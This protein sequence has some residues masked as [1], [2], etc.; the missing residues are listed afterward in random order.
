MKKGTAE[1]KQSH[2]NLH[3]YTPFKTKVRRACFLALLSFRIREKGVFSSVDMTTAAK[4]STHVPSTRALFYALDQK[5][6]S[7]E[8]VLEK[9]DAATPFL[10]QGLKAYGPNNATSR[11]EIESGSI[12]LAG[13][14]IAVGADMQKCTVT[15]AQ[16]LKLDEI[17]TYVMLRRALE[18]KG[19]TARPKELTG[20]LIELVCTFY[21]RERLALL[22]CIAV[23]GTQKAYVFNGESEDGF[24]LE[25]EKE[26]A[27]NEFALRL[28]EK[29][30]E[31]I[32]NGL[33]DNIVNYLC[34]SL[35]ANGEGLGSLASGIGREERS[36]ALT[37]QNPTS[38]ALATTRT[39]DDKNLENKLI[40]EQG[41]EFVRLSSC[42]ESVEEIKAS[43][44]VLF[45]LYY[46]VVK[47]CS[48]TRF[49]QLTKTFDQKVFSKI[50]HKCTEVINLAPSMAEQMEFIAT[51][52][53]RAR[54]AI[55][56]IVAIDLERIVHTFSRGQGSGE[57]RHHLLPAV[58]QVT[59]VLSQTTDTVESGAVKLSWAAFLSLAK[60]TITGI[61]QSD[62]HSMNAFLSAIDVANGLDSLKILAMNTKSSFDGSDPSAVPRRSVLKN[63]LSA[64]LA[65]FDILPVH[66]L[67]PNQL[68][69]ILEC[70]DEIICGQRELCEQ[71]W[72]GANENGQE[73][74]LLALVEGCRERFPAEAAPLLRVLKSLSEGPKAAECALS[75]LTKLPAVA[76]P[77]PDCDVAEVAI[78]QAS[79]KSRVDRSSGKIFGHVVCATPIAS[80]KVP[81]ACIPSNCRGVAIPSSS[82]SG[83]NLIVWSEPADGL[84]ITLSRIGNLSSVARRRREHITPEDR[85]ELH[86]ALSF[87]AVALE[88]APSFAAP[89]L[90]CD[91]HASASEIGGTPSDVL[92]ALAL[93]LRVEKSDD[94]SIQA[95]ALAALRPLAAAAPRRAADVVL[96]TPFFTEDD[97]AS[98]TNGVTASQCLQFEESRGVHDSIKALCALSE[99]FLLAGECG[100]ESQLLFQR[101]ALY[102]LLRFDSWR[103]LERSEKWVVHKCAS[104]AL[105]A[106]L[107][108]SK[109]EY[110]E[111]MCMVDDATLENG[112]ERSS[113]SPKQTFSIRTCVFLMNDEQTLAGALAPLRF[114][115]HFLQRV[116][117]SGSECRAKEVVALEDAIAS[118]LRVIPALSSVFEHSSEIT[119]GTFSRS[120]AKALFI[121]A[122]PPER[123]PPM[124]QAIA[125]YAS[126]PY[127]SECCRLAIPALI[128]LCTTAPASAPLSAAFSGIEA[129]ETCRQLRDRIKLALK[130]ID[131]DPEATSHA[132]SLLA[133]ASANQPPFADAIIYGPDYAQIMIGVRNSTS[134][135]ED[136]SKKDDE[137]KKTEDLKDN[138]ANALADKQPTSVA[139]VAPATKSSETQYPKFDELWLALDKILEIEDVSYGS[140]FAFALN[141]FW[142][143]RVALPNPVDGLASEP[144]VFQKLASIIERANEVCSESSNHD[145]VVHAN[146]FSAL[147]SSLG[148]LAS[149]SLVALTV[150]ANR[151]EHLREAMHTF[152]SR[153][154]GLLRSVMLSLSCAEDKANLAWMKMDI[155]IL[156]LRSVMLSAAAELATAQAGGDSACFASATLEHGAEFLA[157]SL[158]EQPVAREVLSREGQK[159]AARLLT[160]VAHAATATFETVFADNSAFLGDIK[161][162]SS[163]VNVLLRHAFTSNCENFIFVDAPVGLGGGSVYGDSYVYDS[164]W[165]ERACGV[166][167]TDDGKWGAPETRLASLARKVTACSREVSIIASLCDAKITAIENLSAFLRASGSLETLQNIVGPELDALD[168]EYLQALEERMEYVNQN[169]LAP[170]FANVG[171]TALAARNDGIKGRARDEEKEN[172]QQNS[173]GFSLIQPSI[174]EKWSHHSRRETVNMVALELIHAVQKRRSESPR[175]VSLIVAL[176]DFLEISARLWSCSR[177]N[178]PAN[179]NDSANKDYEA[180]KN[181]ARAACALLASKICPHSHIACAHVCVAFERS[182]SCWSKEANA[183]DAAKAIDIGNVASQAIPH[184]RA[185]AVSKA[186]PAASSV[187][188][189]RLLTKLFGND[190][191]FASPSMLILGSDDDSSAAF[192]PD[193]T[194]AFAS[195]DN[196]SL[197]SLRVSLKSEEKIEVDCTPSEFDEL[198]RLTSSDVV[199]SALH[200]CLE[201]AK[202]SEGAYVLMR[203]GAYDRVCEL[204]SDLLDECASMV[205][206][207]VDEADVLKLSALSLSIQVSTELAMSLRNSDI[208]SSITTKLASFACLAERFILSAMK[209][210]SITLSNLRKT[211]VCCALLAAVS[212]DERLKFGWQLQSPNGQANLRDEAALFLRWFAAPPVHS[213]AT[214]HNCCLPQNAAE[215]ARA[216]KPSE[217]GLSSCWFGVLNR[218]SRVL[219][220]LR[221]QPSAISPMALSPAAASIGTN[222]TSPLILGSAPSTTPLGTKNSVLFTSSNN[223]NIT[224]PAKTPTTPTLISNQGGQA[225]GTPLGR[226]RFTDAKSPKTPDG[227]ILK[228]PSPIHSLN[229]GTANERT[230]LHAEVLAAELHDIAMHCAQFLS[231]FQEKNVAPEVVSA[232]VDQCD[233]LL[234]ELQANSTNKTK[235]GTK[236]EESLVEIKRSIAKSA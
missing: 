205:D 221:T 56:L 232:I 193:M 196:I 32:R 124:V 164:E 170:K 191:A 226:K 7:Q 21:Q 115:A 69:L 25:N 159:A 131:V 143:S 197:A 47:E 112:N 75:Y 178:F 5:T 34:E 4:T 68:D 113:Q 139:L 223:G 137:T 224:T 208:D 60:S 11:A 183:V 58:V 222:G 36:T 103:Y 190:G 144:R 110:F 136:E 55:I 156:G 148:I 138:T 20:E 94:Y 62:E 181:V 45:S 106:A 125:S 202:T 194:G 46:G 152:L 44:D 89:L 210:T 33:E 150:S 229:A 38:T 92:S 231:S 100:D 182:L 163:R 130:D 43:L 147:S 177:K 186:V 54:C 235:A 134:S 120:I 140:T 6:T 199:F 162:A 213:G 176:C 219:T 77:Y 180:L 42:I 31:M 188:A 18:E 80:S 135:D 26:Q 39:N 116:Y 61:S 15:L 12:D 203:T 230:N 207:P 74:P 128:P 114:D 73:A 52:D 23:L 227:G 153:D 10:Q 233:V 71:F 96:N 179:Q 172:N 93:S 3:T 67:L 53:I 165:I 184:V 98:S 173:R 9:L 228:S 129:D 211:K 27:E 66:A 111:K 200:A 99:T 154:E 91:L 22:K 81:G 218:G 13:K 171:I 158:L 204:A 35:L 168:T 189:L 192:I 206:A 72:E 50:P 87:I 85:L 108:T 16:L 83:T 212:S 78:K 151:S 185:L 101:S 119:G 84:Y 76:L 132:I 216:H 209:P 107:L 160:D 141:I 82:S 117:E 63:V 234:E 40:R 88:N 146:A 236:I 118:V 2:N 8:K 1:M 97:K 105:Q 214:S 145:D 57:A 123:G 37:V 65:G 166:F 167:N 174:L 149:E 48:S 121:Q 133:S 30:D 102:A 175:Q 19:I 109:F 169:L 41:E 155:F 64:T 51:C 24:S 161:H 49:L 17:Q 79:N 90:K 29:L 127:A 28:S 195:G 215:E 187:C 59:T 104:R 14:K 225:L 201:F 220:S 126:Y 142:K 217:T 95:M 70:F 157:R 122:P 198:A 86:A